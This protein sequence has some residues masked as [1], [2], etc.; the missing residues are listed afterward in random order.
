MQN[1]FQTIFYIF[2]SC[3]RKRSIDR[4]SNYLTDGSIAL[5]LNNNEWWEQIFCFCRKSPNTNA[6]KEPIF[7]FVV[8]FEIP[9]SDIT[10]YIPA[11][12]RHFDDAVFDQRSQIYWNLKICIPVFAD[13]AHSLKIMWFLIWKKKPF[14]RSFLAYTYLTAVDF[15]ISL[16]QSNIN[17]ESRSFFVGLFKPTTYCYH[18]FCFALLVDCSNCIM[19]R[20]SISLRAICA[21]W[22]VLL[23]FC[24]RNIQV[25]HELFIPK[26]QRPC[27]P[28]HAH[29]ID[30]SSCFISKYLLKN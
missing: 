5:G 26:K 30:Q 14:T 27:Q 12:Q 24:Q 3:E 6:S 4:I 10:C 19:W 22:Y 11:A 16:K 2:F 23:I 13:W 25:Y 8:L 17:F 28:K 1:V 29:L 18:P 20:G 21:K 15:P 7:G 9:S